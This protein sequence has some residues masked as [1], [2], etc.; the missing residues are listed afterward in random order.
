MRVGIKRNDLQ[1]RLRDRVVI[2]VIWKP[3]LAGVRWTSRVLVRVELRASVILALHVRQGLHRGARC[4][5]VIVSVIMITQNRK[6]GDV[7]QRASWI[8]HA[9]DVRP[10]QV[11]CAGRDPA[12]IEVVTD[13][14]NEEQ[15]F[16]RC[17][18][19]LNVLL[20][21]CCHV[22]LTRPRTA[23]SAP[24]AKDEKVVV[25]AG[26][27]HLDPHGVVA[28]VDVSVGA[29]TTRWRTLRRAFWDVWRRRSPAASQH[30][31]VGRGATIAWEPFTTFMHKARWAVL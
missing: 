26:G 7:E 3:E 17:L 21:P 23:G 6:P 5:R 12:P 18:L 24:V 19:L 9:V 28:V 10:L 31:P 1:V 20:H 16:P 15:I 8:I 27:V 2:V 13:C 14:G 25:A 29:P 22:C 4:E 30:H 11:P